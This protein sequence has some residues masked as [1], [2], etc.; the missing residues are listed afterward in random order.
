MDFV[1]IIERSK[2]DEIEIFPDFQTGDVEDLLGRGKSFYA[3][4]NEQEGIWSQK[5]NDV[6]KLVDAE[7][8]DYVEEVK[9]RQFTGRLNVKTLKS[10]A[11][12][13][14]NRFTQYM[15]RFPDSGINLDNKLT[16][17][18]TKVKK[19]D[20]VSKRLPY[21]LSDGPHDAWDQLVDTLYSPSEREKIEWSI[22]AIVSGDSRKIQ[23]FFVLYGPPGKGKGTILKIIEKLFSGYCITFD[24]KALGMSNDQFSMEVFRSNPLVAIDGDGNLSRIEDNTRLNS[25]V[26]HEPVVVNEKGKTRYSTV[27]NCFL[28]IA[29]NDPVKITN[30]KSGIIRRLIDINPTGKE[31]KPKEYEK[32]ISQIDFELGAIAKH[33]LDVYRDLGKNYY[34]NYVPSQMIEKTD[35]FY[36][37]V[38]A[39]VDIFEE[40][41][42]GISLK[43]AYAMYKE[44]CE[45]AL[46]EFKLPMYKFREEL[47]NYFDNFDQKARVDGKEVRSWYSGF[48]RE[49]LEP[50][51][52][53]KEEKPLPLVLDCTKS[54]LDDVLADCPAQYAKE[55]GSPMYAWGEVETVL[56]DLDTSRVHYV[57]TQ[58]YDRQLICVDFD[59][60]NSFGEKDMLLNLEA[61]SK[62]PVTY[63]EFSKGGCGVHLY[64]IY[65]GDVS[66]LSAVFG[67]GIEIKV[68]RG[69]A[70]L[71]RRMSKCND[72]PIAHLVEGT[73]PLKEEKMIDTF[74][75]KD[76]NHLINAIKKSL[77]KGDNVGG[78]KCEIDLINKNLNDAYESG[79]YYDVS[80]MAHDILT[81]AMHSTNNS[82]YCMKIVS[83]MKFKCKELEKAEAESFTE[84]ARDNVDPED[85]LK[86][87][88][89]F[90]IEM[91][92]PTEKDELD[93]DGKENPGLF[94][95]CW[96][97]FGKGDTQNDV[98]SMVNP[99]PHE[100]EDFVK[101]QL[102]GFNNLSYDNPMLYYRMLGYNNKR[103]FDLSTRIIN[104]K[105][106]EAVPYEA[107][108][109]SYIDIYDMCS[110]KKGLK[111]WE[112]ELD[113]PHMEMDIPWD[114]PAPERLWPRVIEYCKNDVLATEAVLQARMGD[115]K[116]RQIMADMSDGI[117]NDRSNALSAK[118]V[119]EGNR[120]PQDQ[121]NYR[122]MSDMS[123][124]SD[125]YDDVIRQL[126]L[127]P[128]YTK[129]DSKGRPIFP[130]YEFKII[131]KMVSGKETYTP[132]STYRGE[133]VGEGGYVFARP[134]IWTNIRTQDISGMHPSSIIAE[135]LFGD[136]YTKRFAEIVKART[137][138][139]HK[140]FDKARS[141]LDGKLAKYLDDESMAKS[142]SNALKIVVNSVYGQTAAKYENA[143]RDKRNKDNIVAKRGALFMVNLRHEVER[144]GYT[145]VHCKTDSIKV[146]NTTDEIIDFIRA[147]GKLYGYSFE[148]EADYERLCLVNDAVYIAY[149]RTEGWSATGAQFQ[150]PY[151][152]K[153]LFSGEPLIFKDLCE[154]KSVTGGAIYLDMNEKLPDVSAAEEELARR[155]FNET[156]SDKPKK[157][158]PVF[159]EKTD[160]E[161]RLDIARGH[162]YKFVGKVGLFTP[163]KPGLGGGLL[164]REKDGKYS[165]VAGG[166][167]Y[168]WLESELVK[169]SNRE[170][171]VDMKYYDDMAAEA[172]SA[173]EK[174][175]S[176]ER[177]IDTSRPYEDDRPKAKAVDIYSEDETEDDDPPWS[178][179][180]P[181]VPC[182]DGKYNTCMECPN[183]SGDIC[184]AGYSL[185]VNGGGAA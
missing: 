92:R 77:R 13:M 128:E 143:F 44:Y 102:G 78:T 98:Y 180:P 1:K 172:M 155:I 114:K 42:D 72:I 99:K 138:I 30:A 147:Y 56:R 3:V 88:I 134:G 9:K 177:F 104:E 113:K 174:F 66:Q 162:D 153:T 145:V 8:W 93:A 135:N 25:I 60:R 48:K 31:L 89:V 75:L 15:K 70:A 40:Q 37:F 166:K 29:S 164:L 35:V 122:D 22:G 158:S 154:T 159:K 124:V 119:F 86:N 179:L 12:G 10:D 57:Q 46:V 2:R 74:K 181:I 80:D 51:V 28:Y 94:L 65:D 83:G 111:K 175:G 59:I 130:G 55:D 4:W 39:N 33:C 26:S 34:K 53:K 151:V 109:I 168:R 24:A 64:Y 127:D 96:K 120:H 148:T 163:I 90:D 43:Q 110:E 6:Q 126:D 117:V 32:L 81:F 20:Y 140:E 52:L 41:E 21:S 47:K 103:L 112:I 79:M 68:F 156:H 11:S 18:D 118:F 76:Q 106:K 160:E 121:F 82:D 16:F 136:Y 71:R 171:D 97:Y 152:F 36:N 183:C 105:A 101:N 173:I 100:V 169:E 157:L 14:W 49:K 170:T 23:K 161:V 38:D 19:S 125:I 87:L 45:E 115:F 69:K 144:R 50:P 142:L 129:F 165:S 132:V 73:L 141:M 61:A 7:I 176:F 167:G 184:K 62:W 27:M 146:A 84:G 58:K 123:D 150:Q 133:T 85:P 182:G 67:D 185:A 116:A 178:D 17:S 108:K 5:E 137:Y 139:K 149:E 63:T 107:R 91:Y 54:L 95:I 131:K